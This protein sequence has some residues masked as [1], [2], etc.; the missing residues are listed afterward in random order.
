[1]VGLREGIGFRS[2]FLNAFP[3]LKTVL[4]LKELRPCHEQGHF[5]C[6][7]RHLYE[8]LNNM[9]VYILLLLVT[10]L[11]GQEFDVATVKPSDPHSPTYTI[12]GIS[13][14]PKSF[15]FTPGG[16]LQTIGSTLKDLIV[17]AYDVL[18]NRT[19]GGP[20]W[21]AVD[22]YDVTAKV[23]EGEG[24]PAALTDAE[25]QRWTE[26]IRLRTRTLLASRF[27]LAVHKETREFAMYELHVDKNG[28][29]A[30]ALKE[31]NATL[32]ISFRGNVMLGNGG[33]M[34]ELVSLLSSQL[35]KPVVDKTGLTGKYDFTLRWATEQ[36]SPVPGTPTGDPEKSPS[37]FTALREQ[38]GLRLDSTR[39]PL[40][41][42]V[43]DRAEK[44][45][46]N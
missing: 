8:Y 12:G 20:P 11:P 29:K 15:H 30:D 1:M 2:S 35:Q 44:P 41:V 26:R 32:G 34:H 38:L 45:S 46:E 7:L 22:R 5:F 21:A 14:A 24:D 28:P 18:P 4:R 42:L 39:G 33:D 31:S 3:G 17:L 6:N 25:R 10:A 13:Y 23:T 43:I 27:N 16:G 19:Q 36:L 37:I 40:E 9:K